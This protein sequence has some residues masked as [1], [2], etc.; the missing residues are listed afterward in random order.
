MRI[1]ASLPDYQPLYAFALRMVSWIE[2]PAYRTR[3]KMR[4][5]EIQP[6]PSLARFIEC[7]WTLESDSSLAATVPETILPDGCVELIL[8]FSAP[9]RELKEDGN[10]EQQPALFVAGQ[11]T[12]PVAIAPTGAVQLLG[13]RFHPGG[14]GPFLPLPRCMS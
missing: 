13:I 2:Y 1:V 7:F 11:M 5:C 9:I 10:E 6:Q 4:Y 3:L 12:Q 14:T 8:N